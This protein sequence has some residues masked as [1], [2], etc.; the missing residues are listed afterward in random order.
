MTKYL[1]GFDIGTSSGKA[2]LMDQNGFIHASHYTEYKTKS[3]K[4]GWFEHNPEDYWNIFKKCIHYILNDSKINPKHIAAISV[5]SC[6][7]CC[8]LVD[9]KGN[10]LGSTQIWMDRRAVDEC[11]FVNNLFDENFIFEL[12]ANKLDPHAGAIKLLWEKNHRP[13][14]YK[15]TFKMLNPANFINMR[16]TGKFITDY[17]NASLIGII[18]N[19]KEKCWDFD[20]AEKIGLDSNKFSDLAP[21]HSVIGEVSSRSAQESGLVPGI[22]VVAGTVDCNAAWLGN[23]CT[24][25]GDAS[26]VM[27]SAGAF[28]VVHRNP[29]FTKNLTTIVHTADSEE[30]YTTLAGTSSCGALLRYMR[31]CFSQK[32]SEVLVKKNLDIY[33]VFNQEAEKISP[34]SDGLI[35]LPYFAGERTPL[36]NPIA[37]GIIFGLTLSHSRGHWVR[38]MMEGGIYAI[39]HCLELMQNNQLYVKTPIL[40][41]EGG[42][43][44][45]LWRQIA[46]DIL[47]LDLVYMKEAKGAPM[48]NAI[49]AGVGVGI[50]KDYSFAKSLIKIDKK[51]KPNQDTNMLY[52]K[53]Y[54]LYRKLYEDNKNN[55]LIMNELLNN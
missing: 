41:S 54:E 43:K 15:E 7:P 13:N 17:S 14:L 5:S 18:F 6:S 16:L 31:D 35:V 11:K 10:S 12:T 48:G 50:F 40:I 36:W 30:L 2:V 8:V 45:D 24:N 1:L 46:C 38:A 44:S 28:G 19:I 29:K 25:P 4:P 34:G 22:P 39:Y 52:S 20:V 21:C 27:G 51:H 33:D 42:A 9:K 49:N 26:L 55:Y 53:Y 3:P 37:K 23:G 32:E 47:N